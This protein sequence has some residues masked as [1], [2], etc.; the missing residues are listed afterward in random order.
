MA[1]ISHSCVK[2]ISV[3][4]YGIALRMFEDNTSHPVEMPKL[5]LYPPDYMVCFL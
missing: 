4:D 5:Q 3:C 2:D 1:V